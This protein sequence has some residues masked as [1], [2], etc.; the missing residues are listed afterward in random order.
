VLLNNAEYDK[1]A[2][3]INCLVN[4][5]VGYAPLVYGLQE[6]DCDQKTFFRLCREV[7]VDQLGNR[8]DLAQDLVSL[9]W[10]KYF[11][12]AHQLVFSI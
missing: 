8:P 9:S 11:I 2:E 4:A 12:T 3:K 10:I 7:L 5:L 6:T 1:Y